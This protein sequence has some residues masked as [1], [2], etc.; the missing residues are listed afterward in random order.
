MEKEAFIRTLDTL[1]EELNVAEFCTDAHIQMF[2]LF[3]EY[4]LLYFSFVIEAQK[5]A[6]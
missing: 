2:A 1:C 4:N 5:K 3:S 6:K